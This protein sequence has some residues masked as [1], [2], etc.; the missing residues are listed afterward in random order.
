[1]AVNALEFEATGLNVEAF[2]A[3]ALIH[4]EVSR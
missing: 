2:K 1:M 4:H 3:K